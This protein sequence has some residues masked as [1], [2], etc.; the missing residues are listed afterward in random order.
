MKEDKGKDKDKEI[1]RLTAKYLS[2]YIREL[3]DGKEEVFIAITDINGNCWFR[4]LKLRKETELWKSMSILWCR[5]YRW[6]S[7]N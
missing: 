5:T 7:G 6:T 3:T 2:A 4:R 1:F